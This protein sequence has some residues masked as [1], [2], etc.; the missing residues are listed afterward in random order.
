MFFKR[1]C[2][3][4]L[5]CALSASPLAAEDAGNCATAGTDA[6]FCSGELFQKLELGKH[7][8]VS[9]W[10]HRAGYLSKVLVEETGSKRISESQIE[11]RILDIVSRQ[12]ENLGRAFAFSDLDATM[13]PGVSVGTFSYSLKGARG[14]ASVLHSY[15]A[16]KGRVL[17]VVS[18]LALKSAAS[19]AVSLEKAHAAALRAVRIEDL[20]SDI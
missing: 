2:I 8:G 1:S 6:F 13:G 11:R 12:A 9:F 10:M 4:F 7:E 17:Q 20:G 19:E 15:V 5:A 3:L 16:V 14:E 18:Q